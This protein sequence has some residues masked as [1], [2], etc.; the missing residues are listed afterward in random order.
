MTVLPSRRGVHRTA[1]AV[2]AAGASLALVAAA[3][4]TGRAGQS[5]LSGDSSTP[6]VSI[7]G[8]QE[9][10]NDKYPFMVALLKKGS[11]SARKRQFCGGSLTSQHTVMT[12]AHCIKGLG[13]KDFEA[14][15][16]RTDLSDS[17]QGQIR[18]V[19]SV[20]VHAR[21]AKGDRAYDQAFVELAKPV[22]G[23]RPVKFPTIGTDALIRPGAKA[24]ALG[25]GNTDP[26]MPHT[27]DR[28]REVHVPILSQDECKASHDRPW[29]SYNSQVNICAGVAG[30]NSCQVDSGGPLLRKVPGRQYPIQIG[31]VA[32]GSSCSAQGAP[33]VYTYIGSTKLW[34]TLD[35]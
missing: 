33:G 21:Y 24:I 13:A 14:V 16:G 27:P 20:V 17:Q 7:I 3:A 30:K 32:G 35:E 34:D 28:L 5:V 11:G 4:P 31:I 18:N 25:W 9:V 12:A 2:L 19:R 29:D 6:S 8:G 22:T 1:A 23:I 15:V 26:F 10:P